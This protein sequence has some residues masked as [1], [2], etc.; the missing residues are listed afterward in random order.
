MILWL[1]KEEQQSKCR[2]YLPLKQKDV[3]TDEY[4]RKSQS[5]HKLENKSLGNVVV[6]G[7]FKF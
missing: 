4:E 5:T 3:D 2:L 7:T 1:R 6:S